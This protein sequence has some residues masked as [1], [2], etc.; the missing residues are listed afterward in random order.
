[1]TSIRKDDKQDVLKSRIGTSPTTDYRLDDMA[2]HLESSGQ[3]RVLR[4]YQKPKNYCK[5]DGSPKTTGIFLDVETTGLNS[6]KDKIIRL[7]MVAFTFSKDGRIFEIIDE[8]DAFE[9]P[10]VPISPEITALTGITNEQV[11]GRRIDDEAVAAFMS[12]AVILIA[13]NAAFDRPFVEKRFPDIHNKAWACSLNEVPW[14]EE[15]LTSRSLEFLAYKCGFYFEGHRAIQDC[16]AAT[17]IL[18]H[19]LPQSGTLVLSELLKNARKTTYRIWANGAP[20]EKKNLLKQHG[21]KWNDGND[22][23][24]KA[25][26]I[27]VFNDG[28]DEQKMFLEQQVGISTARLKIEQFNAYDRYSNNI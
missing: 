11:A 27:D 3:F 5:D 17:H 7:S 6:N 15:G 24:P 9:D 13:H 22:G 12:D 8:F 14:K 2:A 19:R 26:F 18:A 10:L 16:L 25:W 23:R 20:F 1:M 4:E 21:Y 28:T